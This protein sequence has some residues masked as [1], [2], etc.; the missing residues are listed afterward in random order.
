MSTPI[1]A[2]CTNIVG[3]ATNIMMG[4]KNDTGAGWPVLTDNPLTR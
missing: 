4:F 1:G 2:L 3:E